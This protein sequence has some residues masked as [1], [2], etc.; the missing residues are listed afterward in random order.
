MKAI[1]SKIQ[2]SL[3]YRLLLDLVLVL[4]QLEV[5]MAYSRY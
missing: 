3:V 5:E 1:R 2:S 4:E